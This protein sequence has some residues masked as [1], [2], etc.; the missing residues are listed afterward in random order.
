MRQLSISAAWRTSLRQLAL[1]IAETS[2]KPSDPVEA[3]VTRA[4]RWCASPTARKLVAERAWK[5]VREPRAVVAGTGR[6]VRGVQCA[7]TPLDSGSLCARLATPRRGEA[8]QRA[9]PSVDVPCPNDSAQL[10]IARWPR[11]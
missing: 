2:V 10:D 6:V 9:A 11:R 4:C 8:S 1:C 7:Y 5:R 3:G